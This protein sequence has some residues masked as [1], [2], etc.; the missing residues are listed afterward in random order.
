MALKQSKIT[1][2]LYKLDQLIN[3]KIPNGSIK[4]KNQSQ[5]RRWL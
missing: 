3:T 5:Y 1:L 4:S 2:K